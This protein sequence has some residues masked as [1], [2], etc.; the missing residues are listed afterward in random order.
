MAGR[1]RR[2]DDTSEASLPKK[3][4]TAVEEDEKKKGKVVQKALAIPTDAN[5]NPLVKSK[6]EL[7]K[8]K[9]ALK[10][11]EKPVVEPEPVAVVPLTPEEQKAEKIRLRKE[12]RKQFLLEQD[13]LRQKELREEKKARKEKKRNRELNAKG[14]AKVAQ[15]DG[16]KKSNKTGDKKT[17]D[18]RLEEQ[19]IYRNALNK[20]INGDTQDGM[21][22]LRLGV[23]YK[24][25]VVGTG[26]VVQ[27]K[28]VVTVRYK[29]TGGK[30]GAVLDSS[31]KFNFRLGK[32]E[33]IQGWDVG[34]VGMRQGGT[35]KLI[36]PPK[37]GYG[38]SDIGA[39]PG[40]TLFFSVTVL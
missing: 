19:D 23:Q 8:E 37:A 16:S 31:N 28:S 4:K 17:S 20:V 1:R 35:R 32:G 2:Q 7:R 24:D 29:L 9:K 3:R 10:K 38:A 11:A 34:M 22:T 39:G 40:A 12:K 36:I 25:V 13:I 15:K 26:P 27:D 14:G 30:F 18:D 6:K 33:V 5:G 21:T